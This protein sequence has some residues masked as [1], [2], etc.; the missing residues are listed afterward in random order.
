MAKRITLLAAAIGGVFVL[1]MLISFVHFQLITVKVVMYS[2]FVDVL[3]SAAVVAIVIGFTGWFVAGFWIEITLAIAVGALLSALYAVLVPTVIDR[4]LSVYMLEKVEQLG[5]G[6][7]Q[8]AFLRMFKDEY[9]REHRVVDIRLTEQITSGTITL[10]NGCVHL[11]PR[12][13]EVVKI[14]RFYR[15]HLLP[16]KRDILGDISD[17]LTDPFRKPSETADYACR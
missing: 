10:N 14:T 15:K 12:G 3:V 7:R 4:S 2:A 17:D 11:T 8:D 9:P 5:G 16:Q 13:T 1:F 6:V